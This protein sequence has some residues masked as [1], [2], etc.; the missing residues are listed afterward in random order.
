[1]AVNGCGGGSSPLVAMEQAALRRREALSSLDTA[2]TWGSSRERTMA[3]QIKNIVSGQYGLSQE[4][5]S[6]VFTLMQEARRG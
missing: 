6:A 3:N 2:A 5:Y 4:D 1:M